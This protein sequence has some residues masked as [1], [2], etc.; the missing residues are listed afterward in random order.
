MS[1]HVFS[2]DPSKERERDQAV[3]T[4][5]RRLQRWSYF[6]LAAEAHI[7]VEAAAQLT[8]KWVKAK[9]VS[10]DGIGPL[11]RKIFVLNSEAEET[12]TR[13]SQKPLAPE[14]AM[15]VAI[16][17]A[18]TFTALDISAVA[19]TEEVPVSVE[20]VRA[21]VQ[22]L[23]AAGYLRVARKSVHRKAPAAY[24]LI[25]DTG[26]AAPT[27][28]RVTVTIDNNQGQIVHVPPVTK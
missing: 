16:R 13:Q 6:Q 10:E 25:R 28:K 11:G 27:T 20:A 17:R 12:P 23:L 15:W 1:R 7:S 18:G 24:R 21:Y 19:T 9:A 2:I 8:R 26:P 22:T 14:Q 4:V 3:W 5:A